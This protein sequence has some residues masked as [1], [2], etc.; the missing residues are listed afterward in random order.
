MAQGTRMMSL[1][2]PWNWMCVVSALF[3]F[4]AVN[5]P[6]QGGTLLINEVLGSTTGDDWEFIELFNPGTSALDLSGYSVELWDSDLGSTFGGADGAAPYIIPGGKSIAAGGYYLFAN[7]LAA[8]NFGVT[9]DQSLPLNAIENSSYT[10]VLKD[11]AGNRL[12]SVLVRDSVGDLANVAGTLVTPDLTVGPDGTFLPAGFNRT[13]DGGSTVVIQNFNN[14]LL[15]GTPQSSSTPPVTQER[16]IMEIQGA[17]HATQLKD[18][19]VATEGIVTAIQSNGFYIQDPHGDG[20]ANT[21]DGLFVFTGAG[22]PLKPATGDIG[23]LARVTGTA[24]EFFNKTQLT[25]VSSVSLSETQLTIAPTVIGT[26]GVL[27]PDRIVDDAGS[28]VF[29]RT[30][31][32]RD[33]YESLEGMLVTLPD[34]VATGELF[35]QFGEFY[36]VGNRGANATAM[37]SRGGITISADAAA[38]NP[39]GGD[40]N[41]ERIQ[42][43]PNLATGSAPLVQMGDRIGDV[44]GVLDYD[45]NDY[46]IRPLAPVVGEAGGLIAESSSLMGGANQLTIATYNVLNLDPNDADGNQDIANGQFAKIASQI[47]NQLRSPDIIGLQEIQDASGSINNGVTSGALTLQ[48]LVDAIVAAGG[49]RYQFIDSPVED[50]TSGGEPGGNIRPAFLYNPERVGLV[51]GS[52]KVLEDLDGDDAFFDSRNPLEATFDFRG[53]KMTVI[54]NHLSSKGGSDPLFGENQPPANGSLDQRIAQATF[55]RDYVSSRLASHPDAKLVLLGDLNE[56]Q[57]YE[58]LQILQQK[59]TELSTL[60]G[61]GPTD[62]TDIYSYNF[63]G[64]SQLLDHILISDWLRAFGLPEFDLVHLNTGFTFGTVPS[65]HDPLLA[66]FTLNSVPEPRSWLLWLTGCAVILAAHSR[67]L[68]WR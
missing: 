67:R 29:D 68:T 52:V 61:V 20:D 48:T 23:K 34:A 41:P 22:N 57:F 35:Q 39:L 1:R 37:N 47:V 26:G 64:N 54:N 62:L 46:S 33:F 55:L 32:G 21:S 44:T 15:T 43:D 56:F 59:L 42:I 6:A 40:F 31:H 38:D 24:D 19:K 3:C 7:S 18:V 27:P 25:A 8:T 53:N 45:F 10:V 4:L 36:A 2:N 63:E 50:N 14:P 51:S 5:L 65:D 16:T 17:G 13:S 49:P 60:A 58:P 9:A 12:N 11:A 28:L 30:L 66:R